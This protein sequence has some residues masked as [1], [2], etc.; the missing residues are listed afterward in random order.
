MKIAVIGSGVSGLSAAL[1]LSERHDV[2][3]FEKATRFGGH[4]HTVDIDDGGA[5]MAV[6][7]GFIV[8][9]QLNYPN[10]TGLFGD[11]DVATED[12]DMTFSVSVDGGA[13]EYSC[14]SVATVFAQ[15]WRALDLRFV[16]ALRDAMRFHR[17]APAALAAGELDGRSLGEWLDERRFG[18]RFQSLFLLPMGGAIWSTPVAAVRGFPARQFVQFFENHQLLNGFNRA[19]TWRTVSG[20]SRRYVEAM[21]RRLGPRA[22][23]GVG[24]ERIV[25]RPDGRVQARFAD[26]SEDVFDHVVLATHSDQALRLLADADAEERAALSRLRYSRNRVVLHRDPALMPKRRRVWSSWNFLSETGGGARPPAV[27]YWMNRLQNLDPA[28]PVFVTLNPPREPDPALTFGAFDCDHPLFD[29]SSFDAQTRFDRLQG[30]GG[31]WYAGAWLGW[32]F[33][34]DGLRSGLRVAQAL[35]ARPAW[36]RLDSAAAAARIAAE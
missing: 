7:V 23:G 16:G 10:L 11:L 9:N 33:H 4:A 31:V 17:E 36:S 1:A 13:L 26:G 25:R 22:I 14:D 29:Q 20:G 15:R 12:S 6:D 5:P 2:R 3:L 8:F 34:E 28:R 24:A 21:L 18:P 35:G 32:G 27:S 19:V 30:R